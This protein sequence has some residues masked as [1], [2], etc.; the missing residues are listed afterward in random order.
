MVDKYCIGVDFGT[1]SGRALLVRLHDGEEVAVSVMEYEHG[2]MTQELP[3]GI[4]LPA[5]FALQHPFNLR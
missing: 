1:Q 3:S 5:N 4:Q 2:V